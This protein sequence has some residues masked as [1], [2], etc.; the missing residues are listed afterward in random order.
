MVTFLWAHPALQLAEGDSCRR[1]GYLQ[2][3]RRANLATRLGPSV[4]KPHLEFAGK[5]NQREHIWAT[6]DE[7]ITPQPIHIWIKLLHYLNS[8]LRQ[9][10]QSLQSLPEVDVRVFS[11]RVDLFQHLDLLLGEVGPLPPVGQDCHAFIRPL[12]GVCGA[13]VVCNIR[14]HKICREKRT[15]R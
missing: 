13:E 14:R 11:V 8:G 9:P 2:G 5:K 7:R 3:H 12:H 15:H 6:T 4:L 10:G 1:V